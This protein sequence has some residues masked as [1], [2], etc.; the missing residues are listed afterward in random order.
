MKKFLKPA[1]GVGI[2]AALLAVTASSTPASAQV[3]IPSVPYYGTGNT[4]GNVLG[5]ILNA[6][7]IITNN[8]GQGQGYAPYGYGNPYSYGTPYGY[9]YPYGYPQQQYSTPYQYGTPYGYSVP[10]GNGYNNY[11]SGDNDGDEGYGGRW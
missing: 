2:A 5:L 9:S 7:P 10:Y 11:G 4:A 3:V 1:L 8:Y 6:L